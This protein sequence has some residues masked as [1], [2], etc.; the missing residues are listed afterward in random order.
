MGTVVRNV[1]FI[2]VDQ[3]RA[4]CLSC[5]GHPVVETPHLD[6][7]AKMGVRFDRAY[8]QTAV[9][10]P[11]RMSFYT[12]R[13]AHSHRSYWNGVPLPAEEVTLADSVREL[14]VFPAL[15]GKTH[16]VPDPSQPP[17]T[18]ARLHAGFE[19]W[20]P[21]EIYNDGWIAHLKK[22]GYGRKLPLD[23]P[24]QAV[25]ATV[26][27]DGTLLN[28]WRFEAA[29]YPMVIRS[30]DSDTAYMTSRAIEFIKAQGDKP[31]LLHLSYY[32]PHWP[33][34][35]P[36]PYHR[37]YDPSSVPPPVREPD[38]L[39]AHPLLQPFR[40]ER[41]SLPL[42]EE[43]VW[44]QFRATYY[45]LITQLDDELGRLW[46]FLEDRSL[47]DDT[48]VIF[49]SDHGEYLGDHWLFEKE[50]FYEQATRVPLIV[51][52]PHPDADVTRGRVIDSFVESVDVL[53]TILESLDGRPKPWVQGRSL[54][55]LLRN[56]NPMSWRDAAHGEW[57]FRFYQTG[58]RL[59]LAPD[60]CRGWMIRDGHFK[61]IHY[62]ALPD[63]LFDVADDPDELVDLARDHGYANAKLEYACRLIDWRQTTED[64]RHGSWC[65][66]RAGRRGVSVPDQPSE[67]RR[68]SSR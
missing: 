38:E 36:D 48:M 18:Q 1:L 3:M 21:N 24:R 68:R 58:V 25:F 26:K 47:F 37:R 50:L 28:G 66:A 57:D 9:C 34:V 22:Q 29:A 15:C 56:T 55:G 5:A 63:Q 8:V 46:K 2:M 20:E 62:N 43:A 11:S 44:R 6:W 13:Y 45:G 41:R 39:G 42:D 19:P 27:P 40:E 52:D 10:G 59:R 12:G 30:E 7:L 67:I 32:K 54:L 31:W 16:F 61:Y 65:E 17:G 49:T 14:G 64:N 53:P 35:A 33:L 23:D 4:D 60:Q 51:F